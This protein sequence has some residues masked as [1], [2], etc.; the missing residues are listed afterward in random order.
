MLMR[1]AL[2]FCFVC[3]ARRE[4]AAGDML[5][6]IGQV[7]MSDRMLAQVW[8]SATNDLSTDRARKKIRSTLD[9]ELGEC[10]SVHQVTLKDK[11][12]LRKRSE[13]L[14]GHTWQMPATDALPHLLDVN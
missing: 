8:A 1:W 11:S 5:Q 9:D 7:N 4:D 12:K 6:H 3:M 14:H 2:P 10:F 13:S